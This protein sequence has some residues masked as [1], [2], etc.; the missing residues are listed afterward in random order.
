[1]GRRESD[2]GTMDEETRETVAK[3][4]NRVDKL[5]CALI[6]VLENILKFGWRTEN[7]EVAIA[8]VQAVE[9]LARERLLP[10]ELSEYVKRYAYP[11]R[12]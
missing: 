12:R 4:T 5:E 11:P 7:N 8:V 1:M 9:Q 2:E 3:L 10:K 6:A